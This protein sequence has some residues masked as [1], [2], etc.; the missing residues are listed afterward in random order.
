VYCEGYIEECD[1]PQ[2]TNKEVA[3]LVIRCPDPY[4]KD[5]QEIAVE[6][7]NLLKQFTFPF[8]IDSAGVPFSTI[9]ESNETSIFN[10]GAE[11]GCQIKIVCNGAVENLIIYDKNDISKQFRINTTLED[12]WIVVIDTDGSSKTCKAY[13]PDGSV[14]SL[15]K[16]ATGGDNLPPTWFT[17]KKGNNIFGY[18]AD[19]GENN[20]EM[21]IGF[22]NKYLGV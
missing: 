16:Y 20:V 9:R 3:S 5:I 8:A 19:S 21:T 12:G 10:T 11:T 7:S 4:W 13:K 22:I 6:I 18:Q 14:E 2:F 15:L 1:I 17:I